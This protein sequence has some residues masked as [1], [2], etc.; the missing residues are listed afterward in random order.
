LYSATFDILLIDADE[1]RAL[2]T[3]RA[4]ESLMAVRIAN[5]VSGREALASFKRA[6]FDVVICRPHL[7]D[8]AYRHWVR[9]IRSGKFG[10]AATPV[11]V[12][13]DGVEQHELALLADE[14]TFL[15]PDSDPASMAA[16]L[17][18]IKT[19]AA[20]PTVLVVEDE[21]LAAS[22]AGK[23][24][25]KAYRVELAYDGQTALRLWRES[26]HALVL[27]D[28]MLPDISGVDVLSTMI[29]ESPSQLVI[30]LTA[31]DA[32]EQHQELVLAGAVDFLSKP[33]DTHLL[34]E[35]CAHALRVRLCMNNVERVRQEAQATSDF[36]ARTRV[37]HYLIERGQTARG[38]AHLRHALFATRSRQPDEDQWASL[39]AEFDL[40]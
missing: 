9:M 18:A 24:L 25:E 10:Y 13:C 15:V 17:E 39:L 5:R 2:F 35:A 19:G 28:L 30:V 36:A 11:I 4:I 22:A 34:P 12:L 14:N 3:R 29:R 27:L 1:Q 38:S 16:A 31:H 7:G 32:P 37:A 20:K 23:A 21:V 26:R 40:P 8:V 6:R 33:I